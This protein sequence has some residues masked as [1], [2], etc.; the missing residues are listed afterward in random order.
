M[1]VLSASLTSRLSPRIAFSVGQLIRERSPQRWNAL[2][3]RMGKVRAAYKGKVV[4]IKM[5]TA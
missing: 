1:F 2:A 4:S 5:K 3:K